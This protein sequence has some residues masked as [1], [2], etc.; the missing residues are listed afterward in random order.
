ML[1]HRDSLF[2]DRFLPN[3]TRLPPAACPLPPASPRLADALLVHGRDHDM[4]RC[5]ASLTVDNIFY[6][7]PLCIGHLTG[8]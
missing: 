4:V 3:R 5:N 6:L 1:S 2:C 7:R 8:I